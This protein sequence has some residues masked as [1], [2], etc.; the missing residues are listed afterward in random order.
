MGF[1]DL[2][3]LWIMNDYY[4]NIII[5]VGEIVLNKRIK[6]PLTISFLISIS[7]RNFTP[8]RFFHFY[9]KAFWS[10]LHPIKDFVGTCYVRSFFTIWLIN[11]CVNYSPLLIFQVSWL[12]MLNI[13]TR[14][15]FPTYQATICLNLRWIHNFPGDLILLGMNLDFKLL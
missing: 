8:V 1:N 9:A 6:V 14:I 5:L 10:L 2:F 13:L 3:V 12:C 15:L 11:I 7:D 4:G